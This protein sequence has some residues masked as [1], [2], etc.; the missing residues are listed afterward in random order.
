MR[1]DEH[2]Q[3]GTGAWSLTAGLN[4][5]ASMRG[6]IVE[7]GVLARRNGEG[8]HHYRYGNA[9]LYNLG[10]TSAPRGGWRGIVQLNGRTALR[11]RLSDGGPAPNTGGSVLYAAPGL[12]WQSGLGVGVEALVQVPVLQ[13]LEGIQRERA[14][15][16]VALSFDR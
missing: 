2:L 5:G 10:C 14:T 9:V 7:A 15:A 6:A 3:P 8:S 1:L 11:D 12:R 13:S 16:R 4:L